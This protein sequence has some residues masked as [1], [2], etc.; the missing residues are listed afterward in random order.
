MKK[1][2]P[3]FIIFILSFIAVGCKD[4]S[5]AGVCDKIVELAKADDKAKKQFEKDEDVKKF[6]EFC[7]KG[8]EEEKKKDEAAYNKQVDCVYDAADFAA[9]EKCLK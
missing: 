6:K 4:K 1:L 8:G 3:L 9:A 5:P 7:V 2:L